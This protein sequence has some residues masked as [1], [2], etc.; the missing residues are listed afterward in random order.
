MSLL[1][2]PTKSLA[3][4]PGHSQ[5]FIVLRKK[6]EGLVHVGSQIRNATRHVNTLLGLAVG[7][8]SLAMIQLGYS[9]TT[10]LPSRANMDQA[11]PL[12]G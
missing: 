2:S 6:W 10:V 3:L 5:L 12:F 7:L 4:S 11:L 1:R 8:Q 9:S